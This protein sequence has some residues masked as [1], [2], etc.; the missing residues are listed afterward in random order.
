MAKT[1]AVRSK[2]TEADCLDLAALTR[3][4]NGSLSSKEPIPRKLLASEDLRVLGL[5]ER[6]G[7]FQCAGVASRISCEYCEDPHPCPIIRSAEGAYYYHCL[8]NG[9]IDAGKDRLALLAFDRAALLAA[10]AA[11]IDGPAKGI[12]L[13]AG[14]R[15][16]RLGFVASGS[17]RQDWMLTYADRLNDEAVLTRVI[18]A[19]ASELP[20]GPGLVVT[21][22]PVPMNLTLPRSYRLIALH[23]LFF[24]HEDGFHIDREAAQIRL[25]RGKKAPGQ[26][27]RPTDRELVKEIWLAER[28]SETWAAQRA[29]QAEII[30]SRWPSEHRSRP[31]IKTIE[32]HIRDFERASEPLDL[33]D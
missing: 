7:I 19:L 18:E 29:A 28:R 4:I 3:W 22:S 30:L 10:L 13:F 8:L 2:I 26:P 1:T 31:A 16:A 23:E 20:N 15:L 5:A 25:G 17:R 12:R 32:N 14:Q 27:G 11:A 24:G 21:P 6:C 9:R 33:F